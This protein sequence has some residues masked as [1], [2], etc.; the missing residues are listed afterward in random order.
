MLCLRFADIYSFRATGAPGLVWV[1]V[2]HLWFYA[3][4]TL[5]TD[6]YSHIPLIKSL[7]DQFEW[8]TCVGKETE[9]KILHAKQSVNLY[10]T[11]RFLLFEYKTSL[12]VCGQ[13]QS[14]L[15]QVK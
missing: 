1:T 6:I 15:L 10:F 12:N 13:L 7:N 5:Q 3:W 9:R 11:G 8:P 14:K 4:L 2:V